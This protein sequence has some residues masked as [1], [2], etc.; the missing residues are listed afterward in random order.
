MVEPWPLEDVFP[1]VDIALDTFPYSNTTTTCESLLMGVET[2][3]LEVTTHGLKDW[4]NFERIWVFPKIV[5]P[6][7]GWFIMENPTKMDDLGVPLFS[8]TSIWSL[9]GFCS[10]AKWSLMRKNS[11]GL[12]KKSAEGVSAPVQWFFT[13]W[14]WAHKKLPQ[15]SSVDSKQK[16]PIELMID[17][18]NHHFYQPL[19]HIRCFKKWQKYHV[20]VFPK[21]K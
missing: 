11:T 6:Q 20:K 14:L 19:L 2:K 5:V 18:H 16:K 1:Q 10:F 15:R 3:T 4:G 12:T 9:V 13:R 17:E 21:K 8:E 7:N